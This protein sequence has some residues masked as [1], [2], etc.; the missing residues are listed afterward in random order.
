V[1]S[2]GWAQYL[3]I[4]LAVVGT[5]YAVILFIVGKNLRSA[6]E[7][8]ASPSSLRAVALG[9]LATRADG[10]ASDSD[11]FSRSEF[12]R[13]LRARLEDQHLSPA[14]SALRTSWLKLESTQIWWLFIAWL[15]GT[16]IS[17]DRLDEAADA[18]LSLFIARGL[19]VQVGARNLDERYTIV[20]DRKPHAAVPAQ[21]PPTQ[22]A[23]SSA[24]RPRSH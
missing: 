8:L 24:S 15:T 1:T 10:D 9:F 21:T 12:V 14:R 11:T 18:G 5:A 7:W 16:Y 23:Q 6:R 13:S 22:Q 4:S 2:S 20:D 3:A 17:P 19:I